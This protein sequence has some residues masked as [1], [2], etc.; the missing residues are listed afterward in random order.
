[1]RSLTGEKKEEA[2]FQLIK[3]KLCSAPI[4]ALPK[5]SENFIVY[6]DALHKGLGAMLMQNEKVI[7]YASRQLKIHEKNYTTHDLKLGAVVFAPKM[8]RHYLYGTRKERSRPLRVR[9]LVMTIGLNIPNEILEAQTE[10]LKPENLNAEDVGGMLS[11][12]LPKEK[13]E[14][15]KAELQKPFGLLVQPEILEWKRE[16]ITIDFITKL[17]KTANGYDTIWVIVDCV[18]KSAHFLPMK[19]NDPMEKL[20]K[21][22]MKEEVILNGDSPVPTIV[23]DVVV[24]PVSHSLPSEW[25]TYTLIWRNKADLQEHSL[26]D[27]FNSLKIYK[28][29]VKHSSFT[30]NP[31]Q[32]LEFVSSSNTDSTTDSVS[33]ATSV[34]AVCAKLHID[35]DDLEEMDMRWQMAMLTMRA[36]RFLQ[37]TSK[38][39]GDNRVTS[40][41]F[42]M[43]KVEC[44][45]CHKKGHFTRECRSPKDSRRSGATE[46]QRRTALSYQAEE[47]PANFALM[48]ITSSSS[49]SDNEVP[50]CSKACSKAYAQLHSQYDKL[51]NDFQKYQFD[52]LSYQVG[53]EFVEARLVVYK[54]NESILEENIKLLNIEVQ[55]RD[56]ALVTLRQKLN[57]AEQERNDLKLKLDKF[58]TSSKNLTE[59]L[60]SQTNEKHGS[61]YF[62]SKSDC[63]SLSPS[64][65]SDRSQ[66]SGGYH[67][68]PPQITGTFMPQK[69]DLVFQTTPID[70]ETNHSAFTVQLSPSKPTQ[71]LSHTNRP[72]APIIEDWV[73]DSEDESETNDPQSV[74]SF[75]Q[76]VDNLMKDCDYHAKK[77]AQPTPRNYAHGVHTQSKPI[78]IT[79]VRP[80]CTVMPKIMVTR[81][82]H[83]H[84]IDTKSKLPIRRHI[85]HSPSP[86][87]SNSPPRVTTTQAL[88]V[89][90]AK[91]NKGQWGNPQYAL[92]DKGVIDSGCSRHMTGNMY[93]LSDFE[94]LNGG[95]VAFG[96]NPKGGKISGKRKI[97]TGKF[98]GKVDEGFLVGYSVNSK[99]F[100]IFNSK[101]RIVQETLHETNL[102]PVQKNDEDATFDEKE[103][104]AKKHE[105][106][107]NVSPSSSAQSGKQDDKTK[108]KAKGKIFVKSFTGN[109]Y[110]SAEFEDHSNDSSNDVNAAGS[111]VPT[112]GQNSSNS[113][114][115]FS[116]AELEDITYSDHENVG[117]EPDFN[118]LETSIT[119]SPILTTRT[120][121]DHPVSQIIGDLSSTTQTR[122]LT[123]VIKDQEKLMKDKFQMSSMG[124]LTFFLGLRL[125]QKKDGIFISQDKY[126][127]EIL[128]KFRLTEGKSASTPIDTE[129]PFLKDPNGEDVD[130]H[131]YRSMIGSLMYLTSSRPDIM[132][133]VCA[134]VRF[135][136]ILKASHLHAVKRIFIYLKGKPHLG[137]WY[138]K[139]SPFELVAYSNSDYAGASLDRKFT[140]GG[141]QFLGCRL[142]SWQCKKQTVVATSST[143]AKYV[144]AAS[145]CAQVLWIPNQLLDYGYN[146]MHT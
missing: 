72:S 1:M 88:V 68:V 55:A 117:A 112:A 127:A 5:G 15:L 78:S 89:S 7:A 96:G 108:K 116:A 16:R 40:M 140:T 138:P 52:V 145:C 6:C 103:H 51:T 137:L 144:A 122:S 54:Q 67:V 9:A 139:D 24:Q 134:C 125:K 98:K 62:S 38:N 13:L 79:A 106:E 76:S 28:A 45:N 56:T 64:S 107:V 69:P 50:S 70:V 126:V 10:A 85:T 48:A 128:K 60:A 3:K 18:T 90:A 80:V 146:F 31:T 19:E 121:K 101:T 133:A 143:E 114:N 65:L 26:D 86:K 44:Y 25:K 123:R 102:T 32:N 130:V 132:F 57:Q 59:V 42:D 20:M 36:R 129:K 30:G 135:Q 77:K 74:P 87:T 92:K 73:S 35:V 97:K 39:L 29:K 11:K 27:L 33:A 110:L 94:E 119:V 93:Y 141:C 12:D 66:P 61:G 84:S 113:T 37:K 115:P 142:I 99:A 71:D 118:N 91:G 53:L 14:P 8:W 34:S 22:Y 23:V 49:S 75:V 136:V 41:G 43:S 95:Y 104:D 131:I 63:E 58:Q 105:S 21:L 4:L 120:Y 46:P 17:P 100:T 81:P 109:K 82:R 83:A 111:I 124:E 2:A 47:E